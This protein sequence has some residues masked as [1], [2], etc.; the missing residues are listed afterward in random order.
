MKD[1]LEIEMKDVEEFLK[2]KNLTNIEYINDFL[3]LSDYTRN[4]VSEKEY[5][6]LSKLI[7]YIQENEF[8]EALSWIIS[9][10][11]EN[12]NQDFLCDLGNKINNF[13]EFTNVLK[14]EEDPYISGIKKVTEKYD[15]VESFFNLLIYKTRYKGAFLISMEKFDTKDNDFIQYKLLITKNIQKYIE[16]NKYE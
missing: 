6:K 2:D 16:N 14:I 1:K 12:C 15:E 8:F 4:L 3:E 13:D 7:K 9:I 10:L 5:A 11:E